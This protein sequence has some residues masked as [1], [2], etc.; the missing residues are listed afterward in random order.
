[1]EYLLVANH[2]LI[3]PHSEQRPLLRA[4]PQIYRFLASSSAKFPTDKFAIVFASHCR[5]KKIFY[6]FC[7]FGTSLLVAT[8]LAAWVCLG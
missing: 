2:H 4:A 6:H 7:F 8:S 3:D 1:M 5:I